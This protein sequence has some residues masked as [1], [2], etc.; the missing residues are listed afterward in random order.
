MLANALRSTK[1]KNLISQIV[2]KDDKL[3]RTSPAIA[4]AFQDY[5]LTLYDL[6]AQ[7]SAQPQDH[8]QLDSI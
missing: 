7:P 4:Q 1:V 8:R 6:G 3:F 5:Y 2:I